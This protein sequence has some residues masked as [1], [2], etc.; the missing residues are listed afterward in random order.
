VLLVDKRRTNEGVPLGVVTVI[1]FLSGLTTVAVVLTTSG[2]NVPE[3]D[4]LRGFAF[5]SCLAEGYRGTPFAVDADRVA[6]MY[7]EVGKTIR[8]EV[9][10]R[11][12]R[13]AQDAHPEKRAV[14]DNANVAIMVCLEL[15][16]S[17]G[18]RAA[19]SGRAAAKK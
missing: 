2:R 1:R 12:R 9:Y 13:V 15:Y 14:V 3:R 7:M 17:A 4:L 19:I 18:L 10:E 8:P 5:A 6:G 11:L 16:E